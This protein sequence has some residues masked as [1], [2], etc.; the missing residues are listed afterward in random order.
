MQ[1]DN[2]HSPIGNSKK[3]NDILKLISIKEEQFPTFHNTSATITMTCS[4]GM[5]IIPQGRLSIIPRDQREFPMEAI[6]FPQG[7]V[8]V[9]RVICLVPCNAQL[10]FC[11]TKCSLEEYTTTPRGHKI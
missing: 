5:T 7:R 3:M 11:L 10:S 8:I 4:Q 6:I 2:M 1:Y 9:P